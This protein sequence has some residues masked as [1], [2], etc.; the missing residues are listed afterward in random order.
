MGEPIHKKTPPRLTHLWASYDCPLYFITFNTW[1]RHSCLACADVHRSF[2]DYG[3]KNADAGRAIGRY[4]IMPDH[5]HLFARLRADARLSDF[6]RLMKQCLGRA[7]PEDSRSQNP[8]WQPGFFDHLMRNSESYSEKWAYVRDNP[9]RAGL[10][11]RVDS[12]PYQGEIVRIDR[13]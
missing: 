10:V 13:V 6:M 4:V 1:Q 11:E 5:V 7:I 9:V 3:E 8:V 12:W 2:I